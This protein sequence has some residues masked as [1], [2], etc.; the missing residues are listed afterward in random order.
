MIAIYYAS[1]LVDDQAKAR[2]FYTEILGF[3]IA[4]DVPLRGYRWLTVVSE[5]ADTHLIL[6][7]TL[8]PAAKVYQKALYESRVPAI[9]FPVDNLQAEV[10]RLKGLASS[11][12]ENRS[13]TVHP[14]PRTSTTR[15]AT[16]SIS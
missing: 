13:R 14:W 8:H 10:A 5:P 3:K 9:A 16:S 1:V 12:F 2:T 4:E 7:P 15:A 6:E 11:L